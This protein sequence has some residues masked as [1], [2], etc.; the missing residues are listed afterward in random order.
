MSFREPALATLA[1]RQA[2]AAIGV[3]N[4]TGAISISIGLIDLNET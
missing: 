1:R 2:A 3:R 4:R